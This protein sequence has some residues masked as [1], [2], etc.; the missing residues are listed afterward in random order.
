[1]VIYKVLHRISVRRKDLSHEKKARKMAIHEDFLLWAQESEITFDL[2]ISYN[3]AIH[4]ACGFFWLPLLE[5]PIL[6]SFFELLQEIS[7]KL[8]GSNSEI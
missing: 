7:C 5:N 1:M 4:C 2:S 6:M 8:G 3:Y